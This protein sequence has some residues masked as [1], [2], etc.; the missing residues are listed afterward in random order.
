[1]Q[2]LQD[3]NQSSVNNVNNVKHET[4]RHFRTKKKKIWNQ[5]FMNLQ[6]TV[7]SKIS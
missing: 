5:K 6:I 2:W 7:R 3:P 4:R 1:M